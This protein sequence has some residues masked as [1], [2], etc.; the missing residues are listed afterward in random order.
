MTLL[1]VLGYDFAEEH[2]EDDEDDDEDLDEDV[3][4]AEDI[5][6]TPRRSVD[7]IPSTGLTALL[8]CK[9]FDS[10]FSC[11]TTSYQEL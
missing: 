6:D 1:F 2:L 4:I 5:G 3:L 10:P 9:A 7:V 11:T 8:T